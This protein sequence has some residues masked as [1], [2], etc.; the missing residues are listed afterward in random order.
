MKDFGAEVRASLD[1]AHF[2]EQAV[3]LLDVSETSLQGVTDCML[4][5]LLQ[6]P[7]TAESTSKECA[8]AIIEFTGSSEEAR[9]V[10]FAHDTGQYNPFN[11]Q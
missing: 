4:E 10:I 1:V 9:S 7:T 6:T 3:L 5:K 8:D 11:L 2:L